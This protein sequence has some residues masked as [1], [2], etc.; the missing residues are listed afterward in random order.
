MGSAQMP[1]DKHSCANV[2]PKVDEGVQS[3]MLWNLARTMMIE[4]V[5]CD[6]FVEQGEECRAVDV[7]R[8]V[9]NSG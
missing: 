6:S 5:N 2:R 8:D 3:C 4:I 1:T 7:N 9:Q